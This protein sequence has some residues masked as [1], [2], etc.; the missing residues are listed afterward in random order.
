MLNEYLQN[1]KNKIKSP[2]I[3]M[4]YKLKWAQ[5]ERHI[6]TKNLKILDFGSG[7][8]TTAN[9]LAKNNEVI[10]IDPNSDMVEER[11]CE[12]KY[13]QIIG[14]FEKLNDFDD[15]TFDVI[16]CHNVLEFASERA[17][18]VKEFSRILKS[19]GVLS[20]VKNNNDGRIMSKAIANDIDGA[21]DLLEGGHI[22]NTFGKVFVYNPEELTKWGCNLKIEKILSLQTFFGLQRNENIKLEPQWMDKVF[23]IEMKVSDLEPYKSVSLFNHVLLR[24]L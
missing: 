2:N 6:E 20:I 9:Y 1:F 15:N 12:N 24:K 5:L 13:S 14:K 7:F 19:G 18:I 8:G 11:E 3:V 23:D 21:V 10:A 4:L 22:S 17:E 16:I